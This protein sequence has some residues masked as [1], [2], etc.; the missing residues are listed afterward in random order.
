MNRH[1]DGN[2]D[3]HEEDEDEDDDA[4]GTI[5]DTIDGDGDGDDDVGDTDDEVEKDH[6]LGAE[7]MGRILDFLK[8]LGPA[9]VSQEHEQHVRKH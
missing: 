3:A 7:E 9:I 1:N 5:S 4:Q 6:V 8:N 2:G